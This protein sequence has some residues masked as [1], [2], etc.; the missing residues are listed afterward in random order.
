M[1]KCSAAASPGRRAGLAGP[2]EERQETYWITGIGPWRTSDDGQDPKTSRDDPTAN[3]R[4]PLLDD[5]DAEDKET[6][7]PGEA[8]GRGGESGASG[9]EGVRDDPLI[10]GVMKALGPVPVW[11]PVL[12]LWE[13]V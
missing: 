11:K 13:K 12:P 6:D 10:D 4:P 3:E 1:R 7:A 9:H 2:L 5:P 8:G